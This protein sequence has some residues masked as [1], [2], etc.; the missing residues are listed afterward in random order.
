MSSP[1][2]PSRT[3]GSRRHDLDHFLL[4]GRD[5]DVALVEGTTSLTYGALRSAVEVNSDLEAVRAQIRYLAQALE[6]L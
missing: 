6:E 1:A 2:A 3:R 5:T 4:R